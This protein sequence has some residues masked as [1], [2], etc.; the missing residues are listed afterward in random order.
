VT[1]IARLL[2]LSTKTVANYHTLIKRKLGTPS[3]VELVL[4]ARRHNML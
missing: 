3:D 2:S 1:A 4:L